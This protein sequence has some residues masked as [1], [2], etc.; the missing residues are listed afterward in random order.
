ML[1]ILSDNSDTRTTQELE[2]AVF[3]RRKGCGLILLNDRVKFYWFDPRLDPLSKFPEKMLS[4]SYSPIFRAKS[5]LF[6]LTL[7][8]LN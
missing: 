6:E 2:G 7:D 1:C 5:F 8:A 4:S 3:K